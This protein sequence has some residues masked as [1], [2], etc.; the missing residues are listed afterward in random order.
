[1]SNAASAHPA[2]TPCGF[3]KRELIDLLKEADKNAIRFDRYF[4]NNVTGSAIRCDG[5]QKYPRRDD[6]DDD[7]VR[8]K[9][10]GST[11]GEH[12]NPALSQGTRDDDRKMFRVKGSWVRGHLSSFVS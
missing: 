2:H 1:M 4:F 3:T 10:C 6:V 7:M 5:T 9:E 8:C 12:N 11:I